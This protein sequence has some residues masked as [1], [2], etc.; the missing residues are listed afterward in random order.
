MDKNFKTFVIYITAL[1]TIR[2]DGI[3][4]YISYVTQIV[5]F[6]WDKVLTKVVAKYI[7][8]ADIFL[9]NLVIELLKNTNIN[10]YA[11]ELV[12]NKHL[13]YGFIYTSSLVELQTLKA[14]IKTYPKTGFIW[15][16]K[17]FT[18]TPILFDKKLDSSF[19]L[20][21]NY[22]GLNNMTIKNDI[23]YLWL[24]KP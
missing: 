1:E 18:S 20:Y 13:L 12:K 22:R 17:S 3:A 2:T 8:Y 10:Q 19:L 7:D 6:K 9:F 5:V 16:F 11:I 23:S 24:T 14:Y 21:V 4:V 15:L